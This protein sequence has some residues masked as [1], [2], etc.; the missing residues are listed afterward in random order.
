MNSSNNIASNNLQNLC[1]SPFS[2]KRKSLNEGFSSNR[3]VSPFSLLKTPRSSTNSDRADFQQDAQSRTI[4]QNRA[5]NPAYKHFPRSVRSTNSGFSDSSAQNS[6]RLSSSVSDVVSVTDQHSQLQ[7]STEDRS[8]THRQATLV[9]GRAPE[10]QSDAFLP[11]SVHPNNPASGIGP[12]GHFGPLKSEP[13]DSSPIPMLS[14]GARLTPL[15]GSLPGHSQPQGFGSRTANGLGVLVPTIDDFP[16]GENTNGRPNTD[17]YARD[18]LYPSSV[19]FGRS[20]SRPLSEASFAVGNGSGD[21][22]SAL[23]IKGATDLRNAKLVAE[24]EVRKSL[25]P[26]T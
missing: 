15:A 5:W 19:S 11:A 6:G 17:I 12:S 21:D 24:Q 23:M 10:Y 4:P 25:C 20:F 3:V 16:S 1:N 22:L 8:D 2:F 14:N 26:I 13:L 18:R 9:Q 7:T